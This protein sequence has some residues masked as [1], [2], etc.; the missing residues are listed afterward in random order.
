MP[1]VLA[2]LPCGLGLPLSAEAPVFKPGTDSCPFG[3]PVDSLLVPADRELTDKATYQLVLEMTY[4]RQQNAEFK[5]Q[6]AEIDQWKHQTNSIIHNLGNQLSAL[7]RKRGDERLVPFHALDLK[8]DISDAEE[9]PIKMC[10]MLP[11]E[12]VPLPFPGDCTLHS[13]DLVPSPGFQEFDTEPSLKSYKSLMGKDFGSDGPIVMSESMRVDW[14]IKDFSTKLRGAM[15]RPIV[16]SPFTLWEFGEVRL[17]VTP[18]V[19]GSNTGTRTRK[20]KEQFAKMVTSGPLKASLML[21][22]PNARPCLLK[23]QLRV[24]DKVFGPHKYDFSNTAMDNRGSFNI[25]WLSEM[26]Q[27]SSITVG[28]EM[29]PPD[30]EKPE[31]EIVTK[32]TDDEMLSPADALRLPPGLALPF[33]EALSDEVVT[34]RTDDEMSLPDDA[35]QAPPGLALPII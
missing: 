21:K 7:L 24:G 33:T 18:D 35:L 11:L 22:V 10:T 23:Y 6:F 8:H 12:N 29:L 30:S 15:G 20:D 13:L 4:L 16:S 14:K 9:T 19:Q 3:A 34:K 2:T 27:D 28:V 26:D 31:A 1:H 32:R 5:S 17:M 25:N